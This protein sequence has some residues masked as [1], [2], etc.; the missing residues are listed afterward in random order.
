[1]EWAIGVAGA[2]GLAVIGTAVTSRRVHYTEEAVIEAPVNAIYNHIRLQE[3]LMRWSAWPSETGSTCSCEG[4]DGKIGARTVFFDKKGQRFGHQ[5]IIGLEPNR[6]VE[7][8]VKSK[9]P[10]QRAV[11]A[12]ELEPL[13][14]DRTRVVLRFTNAIARPFNVIMRV[15]GI[16]RWTRAM[17]V[18]DL[19]GLKRY[20]EPPHRTYVGEPA[21]ELATV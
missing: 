14:L 19:D 11:I 4:V 15:A 21:Q 12:F 7:L 18:K 2:A 5:E 16:V 17:H 1:M 8:S 13:S 6:R 3:R 9:G 10:P 20:A